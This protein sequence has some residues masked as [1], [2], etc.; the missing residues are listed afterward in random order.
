MPNEYRQKFSRSPWGGRK[1]YRDFI[2]KNDSLEKLAVRLENVY[3]ISSL[4]DHERRILIE[5]AGTIMKVEHHNRVSSPNSPFCNFEMQMGFHSCSDY[6]KND[7]KKWELLKN[8][9]N[10]IAQ[11]AF[12]KAERS[13]AQLEQ[14][15]SVGGK[16]AI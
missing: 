12:T 14:K 8:K 9:I 6:G 5:D 16:N 4:S 3:A 11:D 1:N 7:T 10:S 15:Y 2:F 13:I